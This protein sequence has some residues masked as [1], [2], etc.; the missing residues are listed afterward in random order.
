MKGVENMHV[1]EQYDNTKK[2]LELIRLRKQAIQ[3][4]QDVLIEELNHLETLQS[5]ME[6]I[7]MEMEYNLKT[8]TGI[9]QKLYYEVVVNG[10][11]VNKAVDKVSLYN[12]VSVSTIWKRYYPMIKEKLEQLKK[13]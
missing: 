4:E 3:K 10:L 11:N 12:D 7:I 13:Q 1:I 6:K 5:N 9:E 8:L 2:S